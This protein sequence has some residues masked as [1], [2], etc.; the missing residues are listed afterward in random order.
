MVAIRLTNGG[1][2]PVESGMCQANGE[3]AAM[4]GAHAALVAAGIESARSGISRSS[5]P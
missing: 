2:I 1:V 5:C 3:G 4:G